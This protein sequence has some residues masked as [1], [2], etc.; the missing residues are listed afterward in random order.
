MER[1]LPSLTVLAS[2]SEADREAEI[3]EI[4]ETAANKQSSVRFFPRES[5]DMGFL[6]FSHLLAP[7]KSLDKIA[8][9]HGLPSLSVICL[10]SPESG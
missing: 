9:G 5:S 8:S 1:P 2:G 10:T 7:N 6:E 3:V 4:R